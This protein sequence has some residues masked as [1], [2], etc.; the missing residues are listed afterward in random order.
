MRMT[1][2]P[3]ETLTTM[4]ASLMAR[5]PFMIVGGRAAEI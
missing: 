5:L 4:P 2:S 3:P 1:A